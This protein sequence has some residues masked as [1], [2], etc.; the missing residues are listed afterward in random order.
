MLAAYFRNRLSPDDIQK[1]LTCVLDVQIVASTSYRT[2]GLPTK[3]LQT[4][5]PLLGAILLGWVVELFS[6]FYLQKSCRLHHTPA[7]AAGAGFPALSKCW[8]LYRFEWLT[9]WFEFIV[10]FLIVFTL[11][12]EIMSAQLTI[13]RFAHWPVSCAVV[14]KR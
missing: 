2:M 7:W 5:A 14:A 8:K 9:I 12:S 6:L 4:V 13:W 10:V 11:T 3:N 1:E